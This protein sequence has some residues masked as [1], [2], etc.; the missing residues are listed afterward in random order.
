MA[1]VSSLKRVAIVGTGSR[2]LMF[3]NGIVERPHIVA[4]V[5]LC[6][7]NTVRAE[8]YVKTL[9]QKTGSKDRVPVYQ[10]D[11]FQEMLSKERIDILVVTTYD[12]LHEHYI[13]PA[14]EKGGA[15]S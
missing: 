8:Y 2:G 4:V 1:S 3:L 14:L 6:D 13:V 7:P 10:P 12:A 9:Q 15:L 11:Q 5:A